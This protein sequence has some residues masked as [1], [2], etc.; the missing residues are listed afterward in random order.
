[1]FFFMF[2][3]RFECRE[4]GSASARWRMCVAFFVRVLEEGGRESCGGER[5]GKGKKGDGWMDGWIVCLCMYYDCPGGW[6]GFLY[7]DG[8]RG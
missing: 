4:G 6:L 5:M 7:T 3:S 8:W 1:M 2:V